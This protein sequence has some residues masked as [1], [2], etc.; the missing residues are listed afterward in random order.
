ML[1]LLGTALSKS[2]D[3][4]L[5]AFVF[6]C[7]TVV[8]ASVAY[9][10]LLLKDKPMFNG[11]YLM[12]LLRSRPLTARSIEQGLNARGEWL[13]DGYNIRVHDP[14]LSEVVIRFVSTSN[15]AGAVPNG[16]DVFFRKGSKST[17]HNFLPECQRWSEDPNTTFDSP[18]QYS[19]TNL[20]DQEGINLLVEL[21]NEVH[22]PDAF[23]VRA[24]FTLSK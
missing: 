9:P 23:V 1:G 4:R 6:C 21:S 19:C 10:T 13:G 7:W 2:C 15:R 8:H 12:S 3:I 11:K 22:K 18:Y 16:L 24:H 20:R 5:L 14:T 17:V